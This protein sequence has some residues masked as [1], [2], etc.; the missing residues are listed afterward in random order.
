MHATATVSGQRC[1]VRITRDLTD[2]YAVEV[3]PPPGSGKKALPNQRAAPLFIYKLKADNWQ[4]AAWAVLASL[5]DAGKIQDFESEA[6][7][8]KAV[9]KAAGA[10]DEEAEEGE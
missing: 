4:A 10:A 1:D 9:K 5:K 6:V 8:P 7:P 2:N 3:L